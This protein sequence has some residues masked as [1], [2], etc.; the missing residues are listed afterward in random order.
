MLCVFRL[1]GQTASRV[2]SLFLDG[3]VSFLP[4]NSFPLRLQLLKVSLLLHYYCPSSGFD[5]F[6]S[7]SVFFVVPEKC[8]FSMDCLFR[9]SQVTHG[10]SHSWFVCS[11][12][13]CARYLAV[14]APEY[15]T[16]QNG[17]LWAEVVNWALCAAVQVEVPQVDRLLSQLEEMSCTCSHQLSYTSAAKCF[18]GL[19]NKRPLG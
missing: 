1:A 4:D 18:A 2:V 3:D 14:W 13:V 6:N 17:Q 7:P 11:W 15:K 19:V 5:R 8:N 16:S 10:D 9:R 12:P